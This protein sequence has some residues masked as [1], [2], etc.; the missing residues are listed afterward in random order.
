MAKK[1]G[2]NKA[3]K[4]KDKLKARAAKHKAVDSILTGA[5]LDALAK[6]KERAEW[7]GNY[8]TATQEQIDE[9]WA[10]IEKAEQSQDGSKL[11][12][13]VPEDTRKNRNPSLKVDL[14]KRIRVIYDIN[15]IPDG[16]GGQ[17]AVPHVSVSRRGGKIQ[18]K[19]VRH[20]ADL[21]GCTGQISQNPASGVWHI[22]TDEVRE[23]PTDDAP[24][25]VFPSY[26]SMLG[27]DEAWVLESSGGSKGDRDENTERISEIAYDFLC[28]TGRQLVDDIRTVKNAMPTEQDRNRWHRE[29]ASHPRSF[30]PEPGWK[31]KD[32]HEAAKVELLS[33]HMTHLVGCGTC[34][35]AMENADA[36]RVV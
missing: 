22:F 20:I 3:Q 34:S 1:K 27:S 25:T 10:V 15:V 26:A 14:S 21:L 18:K 32:Q 19:T 17:S 31:P 12:I 33:A 9:S 30:R 4:R 2:K 5:D 36:G 23:A 35:M 24:D 8:L 29:L 16:L 28:P 13:E 11:V 7:Q 6:L